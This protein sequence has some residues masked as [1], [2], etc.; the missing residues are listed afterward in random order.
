M[1]LAQVGSYSGPVWHVSTS[2]SDEFGDGS[3]TFPYVSIQQCVNSSTNGD[4]I[5]V[6]PGT[7]V[8]NVDYSGKNIVIGSLYLSTQDTSYISQTIIDGNGLPNVVQFTNGE[9]NAAQLTGFTI[10][11][12]YYDGG[13][14]AFNGAGILID[15]ASPHI[16]HCVIKDNTISWYGGGICVWRSSSPVLDNLTIIGNTATN[17][18]GGIAILDG[19]TPIISNSLIANNTTHGGWGGGI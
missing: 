8:E 12:G 17:H 19:A 6:E 14:S 3:V 9:T 16:N 15:Q 2:G 1:M 13:N 4:T 7:Y 5:L 10:Q 11:G 18:G